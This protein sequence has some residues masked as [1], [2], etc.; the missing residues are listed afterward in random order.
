MRPQLFVSILIRSIS[1][2]K[3]KEKTGAEKEDSSR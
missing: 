2:E 1:Y 3:N